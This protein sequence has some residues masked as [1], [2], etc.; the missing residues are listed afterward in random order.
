MYTATWLETVCPNYRF[1]L[2]NGHLLSCAVLDATPHL[3]FLMEDLCDTYSNTGTLKSY[4]FPC[5]KVFIFISSLSF[6]YI[7]KKW[8]NG[9][10]RN[11]YVNRE[12]NVSLFNATIWL[13]YIHKKSNICSK[14]PGTRRERGDGRHRWYWIFH[15]VSQ[16]I[17]L[18]I[19]LSSQPDTFCSCFS[20]WLYQIW[21]L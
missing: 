12:D 6:K 10:E 3:T 4:F 5:H 8:R 18:I 16:N 9:Q 11:L 17:L 14:T 19:W 7:F 13:L 1:G 20:P 15:L 2:Y 21:Q